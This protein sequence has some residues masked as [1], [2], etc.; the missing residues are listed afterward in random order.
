MLKESGALKV[1][2]VRIVV[3]S[4]VYF[5]QYGEKVKGQPC[6]LQREEWQLIPGIIMYGFHLGC[7]CTICTVPAQNAP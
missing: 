3:N 1:K 7:K 6:I 5:Q 4:N 2:D